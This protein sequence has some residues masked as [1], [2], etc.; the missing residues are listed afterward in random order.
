MVLDKR[1][2]VQQ[3]VISGAS[4]KKYTFTLVRKAAEAWNMIENINESKIE[5]KDERV[6]NNGREDTG[7]DRDTTSCPF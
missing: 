3:Y 5:D 4:S 2:F 7:V 1:E 6:Q